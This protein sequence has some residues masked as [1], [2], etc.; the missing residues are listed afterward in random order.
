MKKATQKTETVEITDVFRNA[1]TKS[2]KKANHSRVEMAKMKIHAWLTRNILEKIENSRRASMPVAAY[3]ALVKYITKNGGYKK[4]S[5]I[6]KLRPKTSITKA[7]TKAKKM[8]ARTKL[9][10]EK[11]RTAIDAHIEQIQRLVGELINVS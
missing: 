2:R 6:L 5:S 4:T 3:A 7:P 1:L 11:F 10:Q 8:S 9:K